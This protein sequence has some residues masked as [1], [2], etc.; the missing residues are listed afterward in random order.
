MKRKRER[1]EASN[2]KF[3]L[4]ETI[5]TYIR[6]G[7]IEELNQLRIEK[8]PLLI[9]DLFYHL[10]TSRYPVRIIAY[11]HRNYPE[12]TVVLLRKAINGRAESV[13]R[14]IA[15]LT[16]KVSIPE[17][18]WEENIYHRR[19]S[20]NLTHKLLQTTYSKYLDILIECGYIDQAR[21][22]DLAM[23][24]Y[25]QGN[26]LCLQQLL[27]GLKDS[28]FLLAIVCQILKSGNKELFHNLIN[29]GSITKTLA[30]E[31][32]VTVGDLKELERAPRERYCFPTGYLHV[33][34]RHHQY[35][36]ALYIIPRLDAQSL[37]PSEWERALLN[38]GDLPEAVIALIGKTGV[39]DP[40]RL[41]ISTQYH[42][43]P[44]KNLLT[45]CRLMNTTLAAEVLKVMNLLDLNEC[46]RLALNEDIF[47][48][49]LDYIGTEN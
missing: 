18:W 25:L 11:Y 19:D 45:L 38:Y 41:I 5:R 28:S 31:C 13:I 22:G 37:T 49:V 17:E 1:L 29:S 9:G 42:S 35:E 2:N 33:A 6:N 14:I 24:A 10:K 36:C 48:Y 3:D 30:G 46:Y 21:I 7:Q 44:G 27:K 4:N 15:T 26:Y 43:S 39:I 47:P 8:K 40:G 34:L 12:N 23:K 16:P 20:I 32:A